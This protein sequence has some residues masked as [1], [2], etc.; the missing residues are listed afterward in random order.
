M[1]L[2]ML[3]RSNI[4]LWPYVC[5]TLQMPKFYKYCMSEIYARIQI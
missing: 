3:F 2:E 4:L 1:E 5:A